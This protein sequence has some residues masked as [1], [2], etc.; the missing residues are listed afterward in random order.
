MLRCGLA[1]YHVAQP[2]GT[3]FLHFALEQGLWSQIFG[4]SKYFLGQPGSLP[5]L[6]RFRKLRF[7]ADQDPR[8]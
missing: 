4:S 8:V 3:A 7:A 2:A 5:N 6:R 1:W